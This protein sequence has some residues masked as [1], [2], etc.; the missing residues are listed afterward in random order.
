MC[1]RSFFYFF[2]LILHCVSFDVRFL[3]TSLVSSNCL[4]TLSCSYLWQ[5][6]PPPLILEKIWFFGVKSWFFTRNTPKIV[7]PPSARR[8]F[9][10]CTLPN[11]KSWICPC[12][13]LQII[14]LI[15][16]QKV[17]QCPGYNHV[18]VDTHNTC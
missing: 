9:F 2:Y 5:R 4:T 12:N 16:I 3:I 10:K 8:I 7:A 11:L 14:N 1:C 15:W 13:I 18:V 17:V 6:R